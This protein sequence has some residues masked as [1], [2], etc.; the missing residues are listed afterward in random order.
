M[1]LPMVN[2]DSEFRK[3]LKN[4]LIKFKDIFEGNGKLKDFQ[5][6]FYVDELVQSIAQRLRCFLYHMRCVIK[7]KNQTFRTFRYN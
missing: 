1:K 6:K 5:C 7:E 2:V 4:L 3:N